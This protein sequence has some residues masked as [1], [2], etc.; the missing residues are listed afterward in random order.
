MR[1]ILSPGFP[2]ARQ[3]EKARG[4]WQGAVIPLPFYIHFHECAILEARKPVAGRQIPV[5]PVRMDEIL[6]MTLAAKHV[7]SDRGH[8][9]GAVINAHLVQLITCAVALVPGAR[10]SALP[11]S[12]KVNYPFDVHAPTVK[13]RARTRGSPVQP[14]RSRE[15]LARP[16]AALG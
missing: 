11:V 9:R 14:D 13:F 12:V 16:L 5:T 1:S 4:K 8:F 3:E 6:L 10:N 7:I 15:P 2:Q